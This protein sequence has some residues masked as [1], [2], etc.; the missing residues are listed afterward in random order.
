MPH[1]QVAFDA[2]RAKDM[3]ALGDDDTLLPLAAYSALELFAQGSR[4]FLQFS[5]SLVTVLHLPQTLNFGLQHLQASTVLVHE[6]CLMHKH[7]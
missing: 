4:L 5:H 2:W 6:V 1:L 3:P 7:I